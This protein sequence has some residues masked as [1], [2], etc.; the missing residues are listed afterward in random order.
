MAKGLFFKKAEVHCN[1]GT[2]F[3][4]S[5][6]RRDISERGRDITS[7]LKQY[8][9]FVKPVSPVQVKGIFDS[10]FLLSIYPNGFLTK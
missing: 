10:L 2:F 9:K 1:A 8:D 5:R 4:I 3:I 6:L 7:V